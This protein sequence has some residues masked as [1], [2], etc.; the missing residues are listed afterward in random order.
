LLKILK[1]AIIA[2]N[3][4]FHYNAEE[5]IVYTDSQ[6]MINCM[7]KWIQKWKSNDWKLS[8]GENVKNI[9]DLKCLDLVCSKIK[10]NWVRR[11]LEL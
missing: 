1:A 3:Q 7:T 5:L 8:T 2:I 10:V 6:F 4:A 9:P 11:C